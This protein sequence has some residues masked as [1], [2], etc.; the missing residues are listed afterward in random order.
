MN[1]PKKNEKLQSSQDN[2]I[3]FQKSNNAPNKENIYDT[4]NEIPQQKIIEP[5]APIEQNKMLHQEEKDKPSS[6]TKEN[7]DKEN[8]SIPKQSENIMQPVIKGNEE[9]I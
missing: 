1:G 9:K 7:V 2:A 6:D 8:I 3:V 4:F 5:L